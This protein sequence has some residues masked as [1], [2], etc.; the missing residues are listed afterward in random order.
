MY[1]KTSGSEQLRNAWQLT[2]TLQSNLFTCCRLI[3]VYSKP[4]LH[5]LHLLL[6]R[7]QEYHQQFACCKMS[8]TLKL[9]YL[10]AVKSVLKEK[11]TEWTDWQDE[12]QH[13]CKCAM[14]SSLSAELLNPVT[15]FKPVTVS[16]NCSALSSDS[17]KPSNKVSVF[18][19]NNKNFPG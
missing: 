3:H 9:L 1:S 16:E 11:L 14:H 6:E 15:V 13:R 8:A 18:P 4:P 7:S 10:I 17:E 2:S 19:T 5:V 12:R